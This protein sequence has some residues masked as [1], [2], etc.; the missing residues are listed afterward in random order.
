MRTFTD[1][2]VIDKVEAL[3]SFEGWKKGM[4]DVWVR[5]AEDEYDRFDDKGFTY[6]VPKNDKT[7]IFHLA[8]NGTTNAGAYGLKHFEE[9]NAEGCAVLKSDCMVYESHRWGQHRGKPAYRQAK[10]FPYYR[11]TNKNEKAEEIG[12]VHNEVIYANIHRAGVNSTWINNWSVACIVTASLS[13]F[14]SFMKV[15]E[16]KGKPMLTLVIL[17]ED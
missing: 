4:Y 17:K 10:A 5:S 11:D 1:K 6:E 14:M 8:R 3:P 12:P 2:Q 7:P 9:Y 16:S 13:K 15:M